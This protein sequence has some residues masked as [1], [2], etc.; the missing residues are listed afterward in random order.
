MRV[1]RQNI[2]TYSRIPSWSVAA[3]PQITGGGHAASRL[4]TQ[5]GG[6]DKALDLL[7]SDGFKPVDQEDLLLVT[8]RTIVLIVLSSVRRIRDFVFLK[9]YFGGSKIRLFWPH[10]S[11]IGQVTPYASTF[12]L[13]RSLIIKNAGPPS[14]VQPGLPPPHQR[15]SWSSKQLKVPAPH[16]HQPHGSISPPSQILAAS[17][18]PLQFTNR[19]I[20][21]GSCSLWDTAAVESC[22]R[23]TQ[24][25]ATFAP[26]CIVPDSIVV[27]GKTEQWGKRNRGPLKSLINH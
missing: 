23:Y 9:L 2:K 27:R 16:R 19:E 21:S 20:F 14:F 5:L 8:L 13:I 22:A 17:S 10:H 1:L 26:Q 4:Q 15:K 12:H 24:E 25:S 7:Y 3:S 11:Q 18:G 6:V